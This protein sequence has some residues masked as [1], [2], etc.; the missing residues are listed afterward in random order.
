[1]EFWG[2]AWWPRVLRN[3][4]ASP[5]NPWRKVEVV[6]CLVSGTCRCQINQWI[7]DDKQA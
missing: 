5:L 4:E 3:N 1:M 7:H 2:R 6:Q